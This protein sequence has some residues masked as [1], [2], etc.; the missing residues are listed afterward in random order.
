MSATLV[1]T[2]MPDRDSALKLAQH[3]IAQRLA[4]CVNVMAPCTSVYRWQGS[5]ETAAEVPV[6][7][8]TRAELYP[9]LER[10]IREQHPYEVPEIVAIPLGEGASDY[11]LWVESETR[12]AS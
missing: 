9:E 1:L 5:I 12:P 6:F 8:K 7:I 4:A 3:L 10:A 2:N 11:L